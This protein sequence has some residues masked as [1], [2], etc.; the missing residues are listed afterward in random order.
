MRRIGITTTIPSEVIW[1]AGAVPVDLNNIFITSPDRDRFMRKAEHD[2]YPRNVCSWI[3]G[4][5]GALLTGPHDIDTIV[6]VT[7]GDCSNTH[8][9]METL[10]L[11]GIRTIPFAFPYNRDREAL[12]REIEALAHE[13]GT[14]VDK[15]EAMRRQFEPIRIQLDRLDRMTWDE[16]QVSGL[17]NHTW[18]VSSSDF[19]GDYEQYARELSRFLDRASARE[20]FGEKIRLG[21]LG[22]P[23]VLDDLYDVVEM[24]GARIVFNEIQR[25]FS[26]TNRGEGLIEQYR[27][28][29]YPY[30][31]FHRLDFII[32]E[33]DRRSIRGVIHYVQSFCHHHIEDIIIREKVHVPVLTLE[34]DTPGRVDERT[35]IR[36]QAFVEMI[37]MR[38]RLKT[39]TR[40]KLAH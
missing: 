12:S 31:V 27:S 30:D 39:L 8:A 24:F 26:M 36:L 37:G 21:Y 19:N 6:A 13:L 3:K 15:A 9:L 2:G 10:Q 20:P 17:E 28:Y 11:K 32:P 14:T 34:G 38:R 4:I 29:T 22:V 5:Y 25:Q 7:Q 33:L 35:K 1:A 18:L 16:N 40:T 23:P